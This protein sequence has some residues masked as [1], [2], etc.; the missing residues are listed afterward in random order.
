MKKL[1]AKV[2]VL[3]YQKA[4]LNSE[5]Q[6]S[7]FLGGFG[8]GK[9]E[10]GMLRTFKFCQTFGNSFKEKGLGTYI[11]GVYEPTFDLLRTILWDRFEA[12]LEKL[13]V[14]YKLNKSNKTMEIPDWN[15]KIIFRSLENPERI[16]GYEHAD[17][18]ID[19][20][21]TLPK[22]KASLC[23]KKI[24]ARNRLGKQNVNT[25]FEIQ[26][27]KNLD[28]NNDKTSFDINIHNS[29]FIT[30]T[31]EGFR[32][33][34][35]TFENI[36]EKDKKK[37]QTFRGNTLENIFIDKNYVLDLLKQYPKNLQKAYI[38]GQYVNLENDI[39]YNC[40]DRNMNH[41]DL[42]L[43]DSLF[44]KSN[45]VLHVGMDFNVG[46]MSAVIAIHNEVDKELYV[47][48]EVANAFDTNDMIRILTERYNGYTIK[49]YPDAAGNQRKTVN[50][51]MSDISLLKQAGFQVMNDNRNPSVKDRV[52]SVNSMFRNGL[53]QIHLYV[54][55][56]VCK[57]L[58]ECLEQQVWI[59]GAPDKTSGKDHM[60][61]A[62]G[63]LVHKLYPIK[64]QIAITTRGQN[65][66][67]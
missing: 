3:R 45:K 65:E 36:P 20:L 57:N 1:K 25:S 28:I 44:S 16:V 12:F 17:F 46:K 63:Y 40:F 23:W 43:D 47:I 14:S 64:R 41:L 31:P 53:N 34:Y 33:C 42:E 2:K 32:F 59:N 13:N 26:N 39:V 19:E 21:D 8:S 22:D 58:V 55:T 37:F 18:W 7:L 67:R 4:F 15:T 30:T 9:T 51:S 35:D 38:E 62:L 11:F 6:Y 61:D 52:I 50:A 56:N 49:V 54:N 60:V 48:D 27:R 10:T 5:A 66:I 29:G 24:V